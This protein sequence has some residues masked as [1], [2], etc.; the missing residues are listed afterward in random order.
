MLTRG[1]MKAT[2]SRGGRAWWL[3]LA[4]S[5]ACG[6]PSGSGASDAGSDPIVTSPEGVACGHLYDAQYTRCGG[7]TLPVADLSRDRA[8]YEH[9][10]VSEIGL[11][12]SGS[13]WT[14]SRLA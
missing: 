9:V 1:A 8:R 5:V 12:G 7:P 11:P 10:C 4:G 6:G 13:P 14:A 2:Q 3:A